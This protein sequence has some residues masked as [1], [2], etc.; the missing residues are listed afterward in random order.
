MTILP[1]GS[2]TR[3]WLTTGLALGLA[4]TCQAGMVVTTDQSERQASPVSAPAP[5]PPAPTTQGHK[6]ARASVKT[7]PPAAE[8]PLE[9]PSGR[10]DRPGWPACFR[11]LNAAA[12]SDD[13]DAGRR[14]TLLEQCPP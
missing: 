10:P 5:N 4:A 13:W 8:Q 14:Q 9:R 11:Q 6:P 2:A 7:E 1:T 3:H 12:L